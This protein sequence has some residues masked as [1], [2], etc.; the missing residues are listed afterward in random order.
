[1]I[2]AIL[3][4][5]PRWVFALFF[6]LIYQ[7]FRQSKAQAVSAKRLLVLPLAMLGMSFLG[8]SS[9]FGSGSLALACWL[10]ALGIGAALALV[11]VNAKS[12][13]YS[14]ATR[15]FNLPGSWLPLF[16]MMG[17]FFTKYIVG[18]GL[19]Q[20]PGLLDLPGFV[21]VASAAYGFWSGVFFGRTMKI[22]SVH[23]RSAIIQKLAA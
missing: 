13:S 9:T 6:G 15:A 5:T 20:H 11:L 10:G 3:S 16:L 17:I 1:M 22:L 23:G 21:G 14:S 4:H 2:I 19:S 18:A 7:G 12:V 8:V